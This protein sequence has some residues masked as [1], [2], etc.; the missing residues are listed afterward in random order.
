MSYA[1]GVAAGITDRDELLAIYAFLRT[2]LLAIPLHR[3]FRGPPRFEGGGFRYANDSQG[4]VT[5]FHGEE[6]I[7]RDGMDVFRL[8]YSGG[9]IR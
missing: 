5:E 4:D 2:A 8:R 3:P 6:R 1:G 7:E 9:L